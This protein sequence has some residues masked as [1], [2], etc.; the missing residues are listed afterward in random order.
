MTK[1]PASLYISIN[2]RGR[3]LTDYQSV[4]NLI[5]ATK[6]T[7]GLMVKARLDKKTY[8]RGIKVPPEELE[9]LRIRPHKFH[10]EWNY[11]FRP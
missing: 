6:T 10:G 11:T 1:F 9:N 7:T 8:Q 3:P 5:A 4:V 2:W